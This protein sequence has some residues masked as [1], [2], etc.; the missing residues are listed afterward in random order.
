[1]DGLHRR[2][3]I[4][5]EKITEIHGNCYREVCTKCSKEYLRAFD[6]LDTR[7]DRW[8]HLTGR[9]CSC[10]GPLRDT[11]V[12]FTENWS[13]PEEVNRGRE[14]CYMAD[15]SLALGSSMLVQPSVA[16]PTKTLKNNGKLVIVTLQHT[17]Y[18]E[19]CFVKIYAKTDDFMKALMKELEIETFDTTYDHLEHLP[20]D[21]SKPSKEEESTPK[22]KT[23]KE[24]SCIIQ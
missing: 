4:P 14:Q 5:P 20:P 24:K 6:T 15:V 7:T 1:M 16:Y 2:S 12:H 17:P 21:D 8:S 3:G 19:D 10:G 18:D 11:I 22:S 23:A 13:L 9:L